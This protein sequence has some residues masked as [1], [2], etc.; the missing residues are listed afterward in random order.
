VIV[1]QAHI[2]FTKKY[3]DII[4]LPHMSLLM[5]NFKTTV[6]YWKEDLINVAI[7][8]LLELIKMKLTKD[9]VKNVM[10]ELIILILDQIH[11]IF[12][13][14]VLLEPTTFGLGQLLLLIA[15]P[16]LLELLV[17]L[18]DLLCSVFRVL[19]EP[20]TFSMD[21]NLLLIVYLVPMKLIILFQD[22]QVVRYALH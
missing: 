5:H 12:V 6:P 20:T 16:A 13:E 4:I 2:D 15:Y 1:F 19:L 10:L 21:Q 22:N 11:L 7:Y 18:L 14:I 17:T 9:H 3:L 8:V